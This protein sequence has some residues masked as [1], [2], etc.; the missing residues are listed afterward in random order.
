MRSYFP[1]SLHQEH[2]FD[3]S[4]RH[5]FV[6]HPHGIIGFST[7]L[8]FVSILLVILGVAFCFLTM[9]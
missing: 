3:A 9:Q 6:I 2:E 8:S 7:W 1:I 4:K 5:V